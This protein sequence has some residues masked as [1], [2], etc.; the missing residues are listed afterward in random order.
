MKKFLLKFSIVAIFIATLS[1]CEADKVIYRPNGSSSLAAFVSNIG[2]LAITDESNTTEILVSVADAVNTDRTIVLSI[3]PESSAL[4]TDYEIVSSSL[5]IPAN[6]YEGKIIVIGNADAFASGEKRELI[7]KLE[8][9]GEAYVSKKPFTLSIFRSC[10]LD[11]GSIGTN[12]IGTTSIEGDIVTEFVP[13]ITQSTTNPNVF[14]FNS[15][16]GPNFVADATGNPAYANQY[17]YPGVITINSDFSLTVTTTAGYGSTSSGT[18]DPCENTFSYNLNQ[19]L[20]TG[21]WT[22]DVVLVPNN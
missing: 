7:L 4:D 10:P 12:F 15:L 2:G 9:V 1:S 19:G 16:W 6:S 5:V 22:A 18:Y 3:D 13:V 14:T 21:S 17:L 20:F 11:L 8:S